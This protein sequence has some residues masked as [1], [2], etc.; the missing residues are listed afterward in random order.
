MSKKRLMKRQRA[1]TP[2]ENIIA[3]YYDE[4]A[5]ELTPFEEDLK[6]RCETIYKK[7]IQKDSILD[8]IKVH[9]RFFNVSQATAY[10]DI[11]KAELIFGPI[12][13]FDK[14]FW[15]FIQIERKR[16]MIERAKAEGNLE[17]EA[18]LE[19]DIDNLLDFDKD[20]STF[21]RDKLKSMS[22][23]VELP[24]A[25]QKALDKLF[26]KGVVDLNDLEAEDT[27]F[28]EVENEQKN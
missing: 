12:N 24:N 2:V 22:V 4:R 10:R 3:H 19:R 13:K 16:N 14:D 18:K 8:T 15:R 9:M 17:V 25:T 27:E 1:D 21:N 20:D 11:K 6:L 26:K 28:E 7:L 5:V 23:T